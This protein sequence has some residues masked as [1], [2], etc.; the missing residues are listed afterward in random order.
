MNLVSA[1]LPRRH[2]T[3]SEKNKIMKIKRILSQA[4][5]C[6]LTIISLP[7]NKCKT[8]ETH[9][10]DTFIGMQVHTHKWTV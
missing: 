5:L 10:D 9:G 3:I 7:Q 1:G 2:E 8:A 6:K 4:Q